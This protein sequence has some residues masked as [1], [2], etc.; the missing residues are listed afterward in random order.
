MESNYGEVGK[1]IGR[2]V[3]TCLREVDSP[4]SLYI[5]IYLDK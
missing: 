4:D 1:E 3:S 5:Y 2:N